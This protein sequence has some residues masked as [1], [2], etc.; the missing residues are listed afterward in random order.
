MMDCGMCGFSLDFSDACWESLLLL[1]PG[2]EVAGGRAGILYWP[3]ENCGYF[4]CN[5]GISVWVV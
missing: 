2:G 1:A 5:E 3:T 4:L